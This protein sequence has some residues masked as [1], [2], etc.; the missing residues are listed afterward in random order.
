M[1]QYCVFAQNFVAAANNGEPL[2]VKAF[3]SKHRAT[4]PD[5]AELARSF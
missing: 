2:T 3:W 1:R 4:L 5:L